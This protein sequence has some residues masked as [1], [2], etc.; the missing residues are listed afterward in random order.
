MRFE[1]LQ[2]CLHN[3]T[4]HGHEY[5][6]VNEAEAEAAPIATDRRDDSQSGSGVGQ[7][8]SDPFDGHAKH[9]AHAAAGIADCNRSARRTSGR[10]EVMGGGC[11]SVPQ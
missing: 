6:H 5:G 4:R 11:A 7:R 8:L 2:H 3:G 9:L 10:G 1:L